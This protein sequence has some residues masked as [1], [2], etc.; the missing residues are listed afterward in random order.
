MP[1]RFLNPEKYRC[2]YQDQEKFDELY[3]VGNALIFEYR[4]QDTR[5]GR[6]L[7]TDPLASKYPFYSPYA[8]S[9]N[10][11]I[12]AVELEGLEPKDLNT[13][14]TISMG[15]ACDLNEQ[16]ESNYSQW[17]DMLK[18]ENS[19]EYENVINKSAWPI[20]SQRMNDAE[21]AQLNID[22][23][24]VNLT[25]PEGK[26]ANDVFNFIRTNFSDFLNKDVSDE[27]FP[28]SLVSYKSWLLNETGAI[29][30]F[31]TP[32]DDAAVI[33]SQATSNSWVFTPVFT[34]G[35][36]SHPLAGHRE[37]GLSANGDNTFTFYTRGVDRLWGIEDVIYNSTQNGGRFFNNA[38]MLW[39]GVMN[40]V[41]NYIQSPAVGGTA[42]QTHNFNRRILWS[43]TK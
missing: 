22:Y 33:T 36:G 9:G 17:E 31:N 7:S 10:R 39:N 34:I 29:M 28:Y 41:I 8:F 24:A 42:F 38:D 1:G 5:L 21:G 11:V 15:S 27:L 2:G 19:K 3:G 30:V 37:F 12:S 43:T 40:N 6:F 26:T 23:Y 14:Q 32:M 13:G 35:D 25:L 18:F 4:I 16:E 20:A